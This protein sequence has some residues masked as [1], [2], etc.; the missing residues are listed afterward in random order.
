[1]SRPTYLPEDVLTGSNAKLQ[2]ASLSDFWKWAFSDLCDDDLKGI[3]AEWIVLKLLGIARARR[4]SW[5]NSDIVTEEGVRIE[6]KASSYWQSWKL[7]DG[8]GALRPTPIHPVSSEAQIRFAGL[9][10]RDAG[11]ISKSSD[12]RLFKS[13]IYVFAFQH[14]KDSERWDAMDLSQWEFYALPISAIDALGWN[15]ISLPMLRIEQKK[16][17]GQEKLAADSFAD[18]ARALI[19]SAAKPRKETQ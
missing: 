1:L 7:M 11:D 17:C 2:Q 8:T 6:V 14:E 19:A 12:P 16:L 5:A 15:S 18:V 13:D 10:A 4:V 9:K 3:F